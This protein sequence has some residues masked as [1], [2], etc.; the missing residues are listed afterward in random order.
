[1]RGFFDSGS[2]PAYSHYRQPVSWS[3]VSSITAEPAVRQLSAG[4]LR[5]VPSCEW[6][7]VSVRLF[8]E[9]I[10]VFENGKTR[11]WGGILSR[12]DLRGV[13]SRSTNL[14]RCCAGSISLHLTSSF[15][16]LVITSR[17][18]GTT[19]PTSMRLGDVAPRVSWDFSTAQL[20]DG[21]IVVQNNTHRTARST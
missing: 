1:M 14:I 6:L 15:G 10:T 9:I 3:T 11:R 19:I 8:S 18:S 2:I 17:C 16:P 5:F 4:N 7:A 21:S 13:A 12:I 20:D